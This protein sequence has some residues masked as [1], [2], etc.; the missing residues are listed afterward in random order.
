MKKHVIPGLIIFV[1][2]CALPLYVFA[3]FNNFSK[4]PFGGRITLTTLPSLT[5]AAQY[6]AM[7]IQ[8]VNVAPSSPYFIT[9][10]TKTIRQ[11]SWIL[12]WYSPIPNMSTCYTNSTPPAP[13]PSFEINSLF[14]VSK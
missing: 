4:R 2:L 3:Q 5:C 6:G 7:I 1:T 14:G 13:V 10:T 9:S 12:G 11:G 8:P